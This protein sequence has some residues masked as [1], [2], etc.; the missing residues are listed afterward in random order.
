[1]T[2][3]S[4]SQLKQIAERQA[5]KHTLGNLTLLTESNNPSL[6]NLGFDTKRGEA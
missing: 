3:M 2:G 1:M 6:G 4:E 5:I